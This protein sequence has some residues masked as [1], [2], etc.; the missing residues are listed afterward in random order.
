MRR[1]A[2]RALLLCLALTGCAMEGAESPD[3][4]D[5]VGVVSGGKADGSD[6]LPCELDAVVDRLNAG[7]TADEIRGWGVHSRAATNLAAHRDGADGLFGTEDDDLFADIREVDD[8][9][10]VGP[11]AIRQLVEAVRGEACVETTEG[12]DV[13]MSP[14]EWS[15]SHLARMVERIDGA[16]RSIDIA[17]YSFSDRSILDALQ[18][19]VQRG[20]EVRFVFQTASDDRSVAS[21]GMSGQLEDLGIEVRWIN[22]IMHHK[23]AIFDGPRSDLAYAATGSLATGSGN[24]SNSAGTRYD[25]N[26]LFID[27]NA[28]LN[29]RYQREFNHL[30]DNGRP[31]VW[32]ED[33]API[34]HVE[35]TDAD[36]VDD[37]DVDAVFTSA[38]FTT[39]DST[40]YGPTFSVERGSNA[41]AD[42]WVRLIMGARRSIR[43]ASGH[44]RS[45]PVVEALLAAHAANPDLDIRI[46]LDGQEYVSE[47]SHDLQVSDLEQCLVDAGDSVARQEDCTDR[48]FLFSYQVH[49][50]GVPL[51]FKYYAYRWDYTYAPQM[52]NKYMI[53]DDEVLLT[54]SYNLSD[55]A[56]HATMENDVI[57]SGARFRAVIDQYI[58]AFDTMWVTGEED[59]LYDALVSEVVDG[60]G[61]TF[62]IVFDAMALDWDQVTVLKGAIRDHCPDINSADFRANPGAHRYC[63]R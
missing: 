45:R 35:I 34:G 56:E 12:V 38:N 25:E 24:W 47:Y 55:N 32:N 28:E 31:F 16:E 58:D 50:A 63:A 46:Y 41:V 21:G 52:H 20:V 51:R 27:G 49:Q 18:R 13:I 26:T 23:Y 54:G 19:A 1:F 8:V 60:T 36:I 57:L 40:R 43:I 29:L 15:D 7:A 53:V 14:Q 48:G 4:I 3:G 5:E 59:G 62:P 2:I 37:P 10:W 9:S 33:I 17:M 22:K 30:W 6:Y 44:L 42:T 39:S 11:V 61:S